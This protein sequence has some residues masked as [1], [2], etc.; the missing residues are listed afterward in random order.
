MT[1]ADQSDLGGEFPE[2]TEAQGDGTQ[3]G[4]NHLAGQPTNRE[5]HQPDP[6]RADHAEAGQ[7]SE[8]AEV[9]PP[10][11]LG[12]SA[13]TNETAPPQASGL[14]LFV[15]ALLAFGALLAV[16]VALTLN[17]TKSATTMEPA[18][19]QQ[20]SPAPE[21]RVMGTVDLSAAGIKGQLTTKWDGKL[22]YNFVVEPDDPMRQA[23]FSLAVS[24]PPRPASVRI[25][26]RN[27]DGVVLCFQDVLLKF[28]PRKAAAIS[29]ASAQARGEKPLSVKA[30]EE[31]KT[32]QEAKL[33]QEDA[34]EAERE[35]GR[36]IFHLNTGSDGKIQSISAQGEI[37]CPQ[38]LYEGMGY[39]SFL[40]DFPSPE[41]QTA[42]LN[43][44]TGVHTDSTEVPAL[45]VRARKRM[46]Y[47][48]A[49]Q[50]GNFL[51]V[52]DDS[53]V[54]YDA[55]AGN[56]QTRTGKVFSIDK[57]GASA[58]AIAGFEL[59]VRIHY[60]CDQNAACILTQGDE[61]AVHAHLSK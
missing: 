14:L 24:T 18:A 13:L 44:Q 33:A 47:A 45:E 26:I 10:V 2:G 49:S 25:Q 55:A 32:E 19:Q 40:P 23:A 8:A 9:A 6:A 22:G 4:Q 43:Q 12:D 29:N 7:P 57:A 51:M 1:T 27:S 11:D 34:A 48:S 31:M 52:G 58:R 35:H 53:I 39:W 28:D 30:A 16:G 3:S 61:I 37:P 36:D 60:S 38:T 46:P 56:I 41:E 20:T 54:E 50:P 59:P 5:E 21:T 15:A 42:R 17:L